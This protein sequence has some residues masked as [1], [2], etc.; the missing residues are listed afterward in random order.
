MSDSVLVTGGA[1]FIGSNFAIHL[2]N[3]GYDVTVLDKLTY[4]GSR[5]NL[6]PVADQVTFYEGESVIES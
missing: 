3:A 1:G 4:A 6:S 5:S 2:V